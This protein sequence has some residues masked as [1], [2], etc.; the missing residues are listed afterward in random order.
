MVVAVA[1][2]LATRNHAANILLGD[3]LVSYKK[4]NYARLDV[5]ELPALL[6]QI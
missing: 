6:R 2:G 3:I 4:Q 5:N 1:N